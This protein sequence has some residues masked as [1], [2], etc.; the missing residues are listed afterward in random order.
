VATKAVWNERTGKGAS[1]KAGRLFA[2]KDEDAGTCE[3]WDGGWLG[4]DKDGFD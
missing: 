1:R 3:K 4:G 2:G